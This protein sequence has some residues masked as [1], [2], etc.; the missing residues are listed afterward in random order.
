M[1]T[2]QIADRADI[3]AGTLFLYARTKAELLLLVQNSAYG[4]ALVEGVEASAALDEPADAVLAVLRPV[5]VC[6]RA[7]V[8]NGRA[9]LRE[10][11]FGD[12]EE[13]HHR[14][15]LRHTLET[16]AAVASV[17]ERTA[18]VPAAAAAISAHIV[19]AIVFAT[20]AI[21]ANASASVDELVA[22]IRVQVEALLPA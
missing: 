6:N 5:I 15:A 9:Y 11:V 14:E 4:A 8:D 20:L 19:S 17:L 12:P 16:E 2:Q 22:E 10:I 1:T 13:P 21:T 3:G 7:R 18:G